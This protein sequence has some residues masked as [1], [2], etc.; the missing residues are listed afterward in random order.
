MKLN[1]KSHTPNQGKPD[2]SPHRGGDARRAEGVCIMKQTYIKP[3]TEVMEIA[4]EIYMQASSYIPI[5]PE[6]SGP[7]AAHGR[8]GSWGNL[9]ER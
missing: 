2:G 3:T 4:L 5:D 8:R 1:N 9:W 7:A 6:G